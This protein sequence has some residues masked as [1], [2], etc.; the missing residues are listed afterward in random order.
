MTMKNK[1]TLTEVYHD[2]LTPK[3]L[4]ELNG[5]NSPSGSQY[6]CPHCKDKGIIPSKLLGGSNLWCGYCDGRKIQKAY[7]MLNAKMTPDN[8]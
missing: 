8:D 6:T 2:P 1:D 5:A 7:D 3:R 4:K